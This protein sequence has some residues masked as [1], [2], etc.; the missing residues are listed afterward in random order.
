MVKFPTLQVSFI[1]L[2]LGL[3]PRYLPHL[4]SQ[5]TITA[6]THKEVGE[7]FRSLL[8]PWAGDLLEFFSEKKVDISSS[9]RMGPLRPILCG[10]ETSSAENGNINL[11]YFL[12][13]VRSVASLDLLVFLKV[14]CWSFLYL[15]SFAKK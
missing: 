9:I 14:I 7:H 3:L 6:K 15:F 13:D 10:S 12:F 5:K 8:G 11:N 1:F 2:Q 4:A